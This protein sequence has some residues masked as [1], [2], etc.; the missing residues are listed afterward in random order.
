MRRF[1]WVAFLLLLAPAIA[2][3]A[4]AYTWTYHHFKF[5]ASSYTVIDPIEPYTS[6]ATYRIVGTLNGLYT[7]CT[8]WDEWLS[9]TMIWGDVYGG[10]WTGKY[11]SWIETNDGTLHMMEWTW[12]SPFGD[13]AGIMRPFGGTGAF[14]GAAGSLSVSAKYPVEKDYEAEGW[15]RTP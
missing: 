15:I 2:A 4:G 11:E 12:I 8:N 6:C 1:L 7:S 10:M 9:S 3:P 14:E 13:E 5:I